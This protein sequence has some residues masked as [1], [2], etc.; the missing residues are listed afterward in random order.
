MHSS[1]TGVAGI[2]ANGLRT[3]DEEALLVATVYALRNDAGTEIRVDPRLMLPDPAL[4]TLHD[5]DLI[6]ERIQPRTSTPFDTT[7]SIGLSRMRSIL[8]SL[9]IR[10]I[11]VVRYARCPGVLIPSS[12]EIEEKRRSLCPSDAF[13]SV[14]IARPRPGGPYWPGNVDRRDVY[15]NRHVYSVRVISRHLSPKGSTES[16]ADY[17]F[18]RQ[19]SS[20]WRL[21]ETKR[22]LLVE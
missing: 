5:I 22:L 15:A 12:P 9:N 3:L 14:A 13:I 8:D 7:S 21:V 4:V 10:Q 1:Q 20:E 2:S 16:S 11:D 17:V 19:V 18:E 6:P